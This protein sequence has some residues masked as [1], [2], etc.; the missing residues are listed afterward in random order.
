MAAPELS[1]YAIYAC[2]AFCSSWRGVSG[3]EQDAD[4]DAGAGDGNGNGRK[5]G[6]C[7]N[8]AGS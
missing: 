7:L 3:R 4:A 8:A 5:R 2:V 6:R 1:S